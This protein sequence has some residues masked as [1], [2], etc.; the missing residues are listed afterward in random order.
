M[1]LTLLN[2]ILLGAGCLAFGFFIGSQYP[3]RFLASARLAKMSSVADGKD[4]KKKNTKKPLEIEDL[5]GILDDFK[6]VISYFYL[7]QIQKLNFSEKLENLPFFCR[8][9]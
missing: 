1:D 9:W 7:F 3:L 8:Y 4:K 2:A 5:A 6:M